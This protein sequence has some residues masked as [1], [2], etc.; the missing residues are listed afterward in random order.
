MF[1]FHFFEI[2]LL[3]NNIY[4]FYKIIKSIYY[5]LYIFLFEFYFYLLK[6]M[7]KFINKFK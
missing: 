6:I 4:F 7:E 2:I 3:F 5:Y 1:Y